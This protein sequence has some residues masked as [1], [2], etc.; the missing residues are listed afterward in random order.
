[1]GELLRLRFGHEGELTVLQRKMGFVGRNAV[2]VWTGRKYILCSH[3]WATRQ[4]EYEL[5]SGG[6]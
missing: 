5:F 2:F 4:M 6:E 3:V 1:V